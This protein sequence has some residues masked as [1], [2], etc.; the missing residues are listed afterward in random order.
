MLIFNSLWFLSF[1]SWEEEGAFAR[2]GADKERLPKGF[3]IVFTPKRFSVQSD[4]GSE[5]N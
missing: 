3:R 1:R 2:K 5:P 4:E